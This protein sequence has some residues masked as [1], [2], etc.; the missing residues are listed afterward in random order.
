MLLLVTWKLKETGKVSQVTNKNFQK[1]YTD[2]GVC[3]RIFPQLD[4]DNPNTRDLP[5]TQY[6]SILVVKKII[7]SN[8]LF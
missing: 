2:F 7:D 6:A 3:C 8:P 5:P 1:T 4:F